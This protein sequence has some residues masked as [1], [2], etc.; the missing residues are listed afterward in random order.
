MYNTDSWQSP[1]K[2]ILPSESISR[3]KPLTYPGKLY[4]NLGFCFLIHGGIEPKKLSERL[5]KMSL[6]SLI[7]KGHKRRCMKVLETKTQRRRK[8]ESSDTYL[9]AQGREQ[10]GQLASHM[11]LLNMWYISI[12]G[13]QSL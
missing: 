10:V 4:F 1:H 8:V 6:V 13:S 2:Q 7:G 3:L 12:Q 9:C 11:M 5:H